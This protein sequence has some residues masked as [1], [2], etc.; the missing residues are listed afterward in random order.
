MYIHGYTDAARF[1]GRV[2]PWLVRR[3]AEHNLLLGLLPKL[4][5]GDH[6]FEKPIYLSSIEADGEVAGCAFRTPPFNFGITRIPEEAIGPLV[7]HVTRVYTALPG[8]MGPEK[9]ATRFAELWSRNNAC[10]W[11][12]EKRLRIHALERVIFPDSLPNGTLRLARPADLALL[13]DWMEAFS[14]ETGTI[15]GNS[16]LRVEGLLR[17]ESIYVWEDGAPRSMAAAAGRTPQGIRVGPVYTP[18]EFRGRGYATITVAWLSD[19]LLREG[20]RFCFLYTDLSNPTS[21]AIY[22]RIGYEPV[23]D[24]VEVG[25]SNSG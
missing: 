17:N 7:D 20:R 4:V 24:V 2:E 15:A 11:S 25:F 19:R 12:I 10:A 8:V 5:A 16:R 23:C 6:R 9:E 13:I 18:P 3:E 21:N 14:R 22:A 1:M